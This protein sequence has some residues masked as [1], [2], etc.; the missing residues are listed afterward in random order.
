MDIPGEGPRSASSPTCR[1]TARTSRRAFQ[2]RP[3]VPAGSSAISTRLRTSSPPQQ[4][5]R[6]PTGH[7]PDQPPDLASNPKR[8]GA[9]LTIGS[10]STKSSG[11]F[12]CLPD[13]LLLPSGTPPRSA[14]PAAPTPQTRHL[15]TRP[16]LIF[17]GHYKAPASPRG[18]EEQTPPFTENQP[19]SPF[20]ASV[21]AEV[22]LAPPRYSEANL[23]KM[24]AR[25]H[26]PPSRPTPASSASS[27]NASTSRAATARFYATGGEV[28]PTSS[29]K[30]SRRSWTWATPPR[31]KR[32]VGRRVEITSTGSTCSTKF[33]AP[34]KSL[35]NAENRS[36]TPRP[37]RS[38]PTTSPP[39]CG[40]PLVYK[41]GKTPDAPPICSDLPDLQL[42]LTRR[43]RR[44][45]PPP[46]PK[47]STSCAQVRQRHD[48]TRRPLR[49]SSAALA[50][51]TK[52]TLRQPLEHRQEGQSPPL[53]APA[54][55]R[56]PLAPPAKPCSTSRNGC[57]PLAR[58]FPASPSAAA[59]QMGRTRRSQSKTDLENKM[60]AHDKANLIP[61]IK[62]MDGIA[63]DRCQRQ[64]AGDSGRRWISSPAMEAIRASRR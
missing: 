2:C 45:A 28:P 52:P 50:T 53:A 16:F 59:G 31:W 33:T 11:S 48:Q 54:R 47:P 42:R 51:P 13:D 10:A 21:S 18:G 39:T 26:R 9:S 60:A 41:F 6:K 46:P 29:S 7:P 25:R 57:G 4:R 34:S 27:R 20:A 55:H 8:S 12:R 32:S 14:F 30:A 17:D 44:Q 61:V 62:T 63:V 36:S 35:K 37:N 58:L 3:A 24:P 38:L 1:P 22:H 23:I 64:A 15:Q 40:K 56:S 5:R 19:L 43:S 49:P